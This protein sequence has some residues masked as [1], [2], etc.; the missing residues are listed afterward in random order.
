[1]IVRAQIAVRGQSGGF[2][3]PSDLVLMAVFCLCPEQAQGILLESAT[4]GFGLCDEP[5]YGRSDPGV[6]NCL[7]YWE[8][9]W[10]LSM[11][12]IGL[13]PWSD[14]HYRPMGN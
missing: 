11:I 1:M 4:G 6:F 5:V 2:K 10:F 9:C 14:Y 13:K 3:P 8:I 12:K 7:Q